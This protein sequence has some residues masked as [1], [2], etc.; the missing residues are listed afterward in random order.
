M[1]LLSIHNGHCILSSARYCSV[2]FLLARFANGPSRCLINGSFAERFFLPQSR[3]CGLKST[4]V[5]RKTWM[6]FVECMK[7][8]RLQQRIIPIEEGNI[9]TSADVLDVS[10]PILQLVKITRDS[11]ADGS[12]RLPHFYGPFIGRR[13]NIWIVPGR[14]TQIY[15]WLRSFRS[16]V[17]PI[18]YKQ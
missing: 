7:I 5:S 14:Q 15:H 4:C 8:S 18:P 10:I 6:G 9:S 1:Y 13:F 3:S 11:W 12:E 16:I 17:S 2:N